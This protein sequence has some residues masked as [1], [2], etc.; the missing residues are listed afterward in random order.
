MANL[1][2]QAFGD[3]LPVG[4]LREGLMAL[5]QGE[6][7]F[8]LYVD[9]EG[10]IEVRVTAYLDLAQRRRGLEVMAR[11]ADDLTRALGVNQGPPYRDRLDVKFPELGPEAKP[12][13]ISLG[14]PPPQPQPDRP[15]RRR[16]RRGARSSPS[17]Q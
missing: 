1:I 15:I 3:A 14:P 9:P 11:F 5:P 13:V 12:A 2:N 4:R 6:T 8:G 7:S 10:R 17:A 16:R